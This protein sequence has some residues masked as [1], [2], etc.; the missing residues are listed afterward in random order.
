MSA[1]QDLIHF[2]D[3]LF[4]EP[5]NTL[6]ASVLRVLIG[7]LMII[8]SIWWWRLSPLLLHP[9]GWYGYEDYE[10]D[11]EKFLNF[12]LLKYLPRTLGSVHLVILI[13]IVASFMVTLGIIPNIAAL[14]CF[15]TL[16]S[17]HNR[18][19][20]V[21]NS[22]DTVRRFLVLF[23]IFAP[24]SYQLSFFNFDQPLLWEKMAWP[25]AV[26]LLQIFAANIYFKNIFYKIQG[27]P[28]QD[29]TA[30]KRALNV[31]IIR[32]FGI[33]SFLDKQWFYSL[34]TYG[35]LVIEFAL[36]TLIWFEDF[37][38]PVLISGFL[39]HLGIGVILKLPL[40]QTSMI[41]LLCSFIKPEEFQWIIEYLLH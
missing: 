36:F 9:Q 41:V 40:F 38:I 1:V 37:R 5:T 11:K 3:N 20:Y 33:P 34:T 22:G 30:T 16:I 35:T 28:W 13:Q 17:I 6:T 14:I 10:Q 25:T 29:G 39:L 7:I 19:L 23:L 27:K 26:I 2:W 15:I 18:N 32:Y 24:S 21:V 12:S 8:D 4:F 31:K